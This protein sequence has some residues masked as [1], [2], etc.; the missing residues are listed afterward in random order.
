[1]QFAGTSPYVE[2][3]DNFSTEGVCADTNICALDSSTHIALIRSRNEGIAITSVIRSSDLYLQFSKGFCNVIAGEQFDVALSAGREQGFVGDI[4]MGK[5]VHSKEPL[6]LVTRGDDPQ[7]SDLVNWVMQTLLVAEDMLIYSHTADAIGTA[8]QEFGSFFTDGFRNAI[9]A[10]GNYGEL[11]NRHLVSILPR[12]DPNRINTGTSGL[13]YSFPFGSIDPDDGEFGPGPVLGGSLDDI[14]ARGNL[15]CG[16]FRR[17]VFAEY[18]FEAG[19]WVGK[20]F[21]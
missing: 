20:Q 7:W 2:C 13:I 16:V 4:D 10:V 1:M 11:Y 14:I 3:A 18:S 12:H 8:S 19:T 17:P 21:N 6:A 15:L 9:A 5:K